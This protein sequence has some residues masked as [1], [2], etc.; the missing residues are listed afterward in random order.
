MANLH[1]IFDEALLLRGT[2]IKQGGREVRANKEGRFQPAKMQR[3]SVLHRIAQYTHATFSLC[4]VV[5]S[6]RY[7]TPTVSLRISHA[8]DT[9]LASTQ[10]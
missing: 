6:S 5:Q 3:F 1:R 4:F 7:T 10:C 8:R 2:K 9:K